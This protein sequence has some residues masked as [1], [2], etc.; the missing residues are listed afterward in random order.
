MHTTSKDIHIE[1]YTD[2]AYDVK[3]KKNSVF[4]LAILARIGPINFYLYDENTSCVTI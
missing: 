3:R 4:A 1:A 2:Q